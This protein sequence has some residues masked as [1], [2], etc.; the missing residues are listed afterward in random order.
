VPWRQ[1]IWLDWHPQ[2]ADRRQQLVIIGIGMDEAALRR[3]LDACL[4]DSAEMQL[5]I[6]GWSDLP[7]PFPAWRVACDDA[8]P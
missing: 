7:D 1:C 8:A 3:R 2:F 4:L 5:G 6:E